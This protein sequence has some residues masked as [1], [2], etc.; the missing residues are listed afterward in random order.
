[1]KSAKMDHDKSFEGCGRR[2]LNL[3]VK[4]DILPETFR[5]Q[6]REYETGKFSVVFIGPRY[7]WGPIYGSVCLSVM[8][9]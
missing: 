8:F 7:S 9:C 4:K 2:G 5:G 6:K 1:M 3:L